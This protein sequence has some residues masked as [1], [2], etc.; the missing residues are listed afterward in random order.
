MILEQHYLACLAQASYFI[1]DPE[2]GVAAVVDPRRDVQLYL[3]RA[4]ELG[5]QIEHVFLTHFHA[6]FV[7]GHLELRERTGATIHLGAAAETA[8]PSHGL[9]DGDEVSVGAVTVRAL[10]TPGHTPESTCF[11]VFDPA[12]ADPTAPYAVLTGDTLFIGDVGRPDLMASVGH[13]AEELAGLLYDSTRTKLLPLPD[14]TLVYPGHGAGSMCG[15]NL[16]SDTFSTVGAQRASNGALQE[17]TRAEFIAEI[18]SGQPRVPQY[19]P[20][21][22]VLNRSQRETLD[23]VLDRALA[24]LSF[25]DVKRRQED[26]AIVLDCRDAEDFAARHLRGSVWVGLDGKF[27]TWAGTVL[28]PD[29]EVVLVA[30]PGRESEAAMRLGRI[31]HDAIAGF[32]PDIDAA[33]AAHPGDVEASDRT[34]MEPF[35]AAVLGDG[36]APHVLDVRAPGEWEAGHIEGATHIPVIEL[37]DR[38]AEIPTDRPLHVICGSGYRSLIVTSLLARHGI[39]GLIDVR[40]GMTAWAAR[41]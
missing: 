37:E 10:A 17:M 14:A 40:G 12:A 26:G 24:P 8:Y 27:A 32:L 33:L 4:A 25:E 13:S 31:G 20:V 39:D 6:D 41:A 28:R 38:L 16:S 11:L 30:T 21:D 34:D 3:D 35:A 15:K 22:A 18:T 5:V 29:S 19:F 7:S 9:E 1:A 2:A 23:T 36:P